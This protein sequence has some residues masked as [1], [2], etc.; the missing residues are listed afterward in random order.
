MSVD[1]KEKIIDS[2]S[3]VPGLISLA[4]I[5]ITK[6][7]KKLKEDK[8]I[9]G[10]SCVETSKGMIVKVFVVVSIDARVKT[11]SSEISDTIETMFK[12]EKIKMRQT[13][14]YVRGVE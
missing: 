8:F 1:L 3:K 5:D 9:D 4:N 7:G 14:I 11:V 13:L 6:N 12:K 10:I 2:I